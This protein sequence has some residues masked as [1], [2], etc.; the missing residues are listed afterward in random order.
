MLDTEVEVSQ[1][2]RYQAALASYPIDWDTHTEV[3]NLFRPSVQSLY[4]TLLLRYPIDW[5]THIEVSNLLLL[6]C[7]CHGAEH[8]SGERCLNWI[9]SCQ[10]V[11]LLFRYLINQAY[12][13]GI[14]HD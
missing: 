10:Q 8:F 4:K 14:I 11:S 12:F 2:N 1:G 7:G 5:D 9:D 13:N 3:S 6:H